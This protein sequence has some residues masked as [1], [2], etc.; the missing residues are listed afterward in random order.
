MITDRIAACPPVVV[1]TTNARACLFSIGVAA[2][3]VIPASPRDNNIT[4]PAETGEK[5]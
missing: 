5:K 2:V 1:N 4:T 3:A